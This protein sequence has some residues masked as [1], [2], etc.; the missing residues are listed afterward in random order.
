VT[1]VRQALARYESWLSVAAING[2]TSTV[3]SGEPTP[4]KEVLESLRARGI[5]CHPLESV[6]FASHSPQME[7]L[8]RELV[9]RL[10]G[11]KPSAGSVPIVSTVTGRQC[12]GRDF[13]GTYW[14]RNL[15][16][17]VLFSAAVERL[18]KAGH[19][20]F[21]EMSPHPV[22]TGAVSQCL[23]HC[24]REGTVL[25]SLRRGEKAREVML[26]SLARLYV[27]G[28][29]VDWRK[30][31]PGAGR[32]VRL[33]AYPWQREHYWLDAR[34]THAGANS[35]SASLGY[36]AGSRTSSW[37]TVAWERRCQRQH[38]VRG[39]HAGVAR[40]EQDAGRAR[41]PEAFTDWLYEPRWEPAGQP[42]LHLVAGDVSSLSYHPVCEQGI[43]LIF[44]D[45]GGLA[46]ALE[47]LLAARGETCVL[48]LPA[49]RYERAHAGRYL[50]DPASPR[51]F[52]RLIADVFP[53]DARACC[54]VVHMWSLEVAPPAATTL[55][56]LDAA[57]DLGC[58]SVLHLVQAM[59]RAKWRHVPRLWLVTQGAQAVAGESEISVAQS[60]LWGLGRVVSQE[61]PELRCTRLD[62]DPD[63]TSAHAGAVFRELMSVD[64]EDEIALRHDRRYVHRLVPYLHRA[65]PRESFFEPDQ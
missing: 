1:Q 12:D 53:D 64:E 14:A 25:A 54:G 47:T 50:L 36:S 15:R 35:Y 38:R 7:P 29:P 4:L 3:I 62:L 63:V 31:Y 2:P 48:A 20:V 27:L 42:E 45:G 37:E 51:D 46:A 26:A 19:E 59:V 39:R 28:H 5:F 34:D 8:R 17:P 24:G 65:M 33:P 57:L 52:E 9:Q 40:V 13:D 55:A 44:A 49:G 30:L 16:E 18:V 6:S 32:C 23:R 43:W 10:A 21:L 61:H 56:S 41:A 58:T 11:V 60:P 22:L